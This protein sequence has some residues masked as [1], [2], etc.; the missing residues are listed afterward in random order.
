MSF[1]I[2]VIIIT[3][4]MAYR[5]SYIVQENYPNGEFSLKYYS[6]FDPFKIQWSMPGG[7]SCMPRWIR[8]YNREGSK[9]NEVLLTDCDMEMKAHW[10][11][12]PMILPDTKT[13]WNLQE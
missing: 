5:G 1:I 3:A 2:L 11:E 13:I 6:T 8:L 9:L 4:I 12:N 10:I 7:S